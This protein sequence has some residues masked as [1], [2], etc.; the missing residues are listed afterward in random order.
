[1]V[2]NCRS[3]PATP[4]PA[5]RLQA[6]AA[7]VAIVHNVTGAYRCY[8]NDDVFSI[9]MQVCRPTSRQTSAGGPAAA[10]ARLGTSARQHVPTV[11]SRARN[12]CIPLSLHRPLPPTLAVPS[13]TKCAQRWVRCCPPLPH[14]RP[15]EPPGVH[16]SRAGWSDDVI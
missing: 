15:P 8:R 1:M 13:P 7:A 16:P 14:A 11:A 12:S 5:C 9:A 2:A 3:A 10:Q 4:N 6:L